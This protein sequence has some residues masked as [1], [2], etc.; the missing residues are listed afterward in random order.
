MTEAKRD[1]TAGYRLCPTEDRV[2]F[3]VYLLDDKA[4]EL[5][6]GVSTLIGATFE[7]LKSRDPAAANHYMAGV[8]QA[9]SHCALLESPPVVEGPT[10]RVESQDPVA[11]LRDFD[12]VEKSLRLAEL[13]AA[14]FE[15][16]RKRDPAT[17]TIEPQV[18]LAC[19]E[20]RALSEALVRLAKDFTA[21]AERVSIGARLIADE[22][23]RVQLEEYAAAHDDAHREG[24]L[25]LAA[26]HTLSIFYGL[27]LKQACWPF[28][29]HDDPARSPL[30]RGRSLVIAGQFIAAELDRVIR[31]GNSSGGKLLPDVLASFRRTTPLKGFVPEDDP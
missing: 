28:N 3:A 17:T 15:A 14:A 31:G 20:L 8:V 1:E 25:V 16:E 21:E 11:G 6:D 30:N 4:A 27:P 10:A 9:L 29:S 13:V 26:V 19:E 2:G 7:S 18:Y 24:E 12:S 5:R 23:R 22:R